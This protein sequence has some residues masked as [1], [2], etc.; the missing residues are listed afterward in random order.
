MTFIVHLGQAKKLRFSEAD[1]AMKSR[2]RNT[3]R[4]DT[5]CSPNCSRDTCRAKGLWGEALDRL[6]AVDAAL[7][8]S[9]SGLM[10]AYEE[11]LQGDHV[12]RGNDVR[13]VGMEASNNSFR[14]ISFWHRSKRSILEKFHRDVHADCA[15]PAPSVPGNAHRFRL[16]RSLSGGSGHLAFLMLN[17]S[18]ADDLIDD[19]TIRRCIAFTKREGASELRVANLFP[20]RATNPKE[21]L[22]WYVDGLSTTPQEVDAWEWAVSRASSV[23][24]AWGVQPGR[25]GKIVEQRAAMLR[26]VLI[27]LEVQPLSLGVTSNG[28]PRHPSR[29]P[30]DALLSP[31]EFTW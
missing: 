10:K 11:E 21:L 2:N 15:P 3:T 12:K 13:R 5:E 9:A 28:S 4:P 26:K 27:R 1:D 31:Y 29:L 30:T 17:P 8:D 24:V 22:G 16:T 18:T 20:Q 7:L 14:V 19:P 25:L 23:I 6:D